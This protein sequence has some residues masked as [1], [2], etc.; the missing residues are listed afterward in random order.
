MAESVVAVVEVKSYLSSD[1]LVDAI[2]AISRIIHLVRSGT[3]VYLKGGVEIKLP[4]PNQILTYIF[5]YDGASLDTLV[6]KIHA[7]AHERKDGGIVPDAICV[8]KKGVLLRSQ[9]M[10]VV[11]GSNV[12]LPSAKE[13]TLAAHPLIKDV[14]FA[15]CRRLI[16]DVMPLRMENIDLD[17]YCADSDLE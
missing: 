7:I 14:L 13:T 16:D 2:D 11:S 8:L 3:Q 4:K 9:L 10:P 17:G 6:R 5:A 15:F 12:T 1:E